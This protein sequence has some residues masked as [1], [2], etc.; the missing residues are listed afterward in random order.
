MGSSLLLFLCRR[1]IPIWTSRV[2]WR[3]MWYL[4][5]RRPLPLQPPMQALTITGQEASWFLWRSVWLLQPVPFTGS[6]SRPMN[7]TFSTDGEHAGSSG[8]RINPYPDRPLPQAAEYGCRCLGAAAAPR[9]S[10]FPIT[11]LR[12]ARQEIYGTPSIPGT[13]LLKFI[14]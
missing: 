13:V 7:A 8:C 11:A 14:S 6:S 2:C 12:R 3:T 5:E 4:Q 9:P 1:P 10:I